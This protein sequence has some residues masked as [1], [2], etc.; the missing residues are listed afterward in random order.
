MF[1]SPFPLCW[2]VLVHSVLFCF[3]LLWLNF[4]SPGLIATLIYVTISNLWHSSC[5]CCLLPIFFPTQLFKDYKNYTR[6]IQENTENSKTNTSISTTQSWQM[7]VIFFFLLLCFLFLTYDSSSLCYIQVSPAK[8]SMP[9][10][11]GSG[12]HF[13][14]FSLFCGGGYTFRFT[15]SLSSSKARCLSFR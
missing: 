1:N 14:L 12:A 11:G 8:E 7:F 9:C 4:C 3:F 5:V 13:C 10:F 15:T 2:N 6:N